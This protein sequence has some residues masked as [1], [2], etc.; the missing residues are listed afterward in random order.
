MRN[1]RSTPGAI[2]VVAVAFLTFWLAYAVAWW[3]ALVVPLAFIPV[4]FAAMPAAV[5]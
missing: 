4:A 2:W 1:F 5:F 3:M